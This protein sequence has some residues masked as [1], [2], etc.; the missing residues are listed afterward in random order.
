MCVDWANNCRCVFITC[1]QMAGLLV[2]CVCCPVRWGIAHVRKTDVKAVSQKGRGSAGWCH[3]GQ[4]SLGTAGRSHTPAD[5]NSLGRHSPWD[6]LKHTHTLYMQR[7]VALMQP[8]LAL[9]VS[10]CAWSHLSAPLKRICVFNLPQ[11]KVSERI[12]QKPLSHTHSHICLLRHLTEDMCI[13]DL[14]CFYIKLRLNTT[15]ST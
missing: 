12:T 7:H 4:A 1:C 3:V 15:D 5:Y 9:R 10:V 14:Y 6:H 11:E 8:A 2:V 13:L